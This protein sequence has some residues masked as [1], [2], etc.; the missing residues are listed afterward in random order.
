MK[1]A[2]TSPTFYLA[3]FAGLIALTITTVAVGQLDLGIWHAPVGLAI[4]CAKAVLVVLFF[5]HA[6]QSTRLVWLVALAGLAWLAIL[7]GL[8]LTDYLSRGWNVR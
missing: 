5:M 4:A 6:W 2:T 1:G 3:V 7:L 8:T